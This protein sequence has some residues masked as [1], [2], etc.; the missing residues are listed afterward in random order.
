LVV[1]ENNQW[2]YFT[3]EKYLLEPEM[4]RVEEPQAEYGTKFNYEY[5]PGKLT[6]N[7]REFND[8]FK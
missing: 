7:W 3:N 6:E 8:L 1:L 2:Y 5:T 4:N